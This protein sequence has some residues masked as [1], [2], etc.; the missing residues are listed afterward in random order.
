MYKPR[1]LDEV[2]EQLGDRDAFA[3]HLVAGRRPFQ[4]S[5]VE[6]QWPRDRAVDILH[7]KLDV[8]LDFERKRIAG[9]ATH[10]LTAIVDELK[11]LEFDATE[12]EIGSVRVGRESASFQSQDGKVQVTLPRALKAGAE[13][14]VAI[15]YS[16]APRRG[17]YFV[18]PDSAYPDKPVEAWTQGEDEDSRYWFPCYDY[19]NDRATSEVIATVPDHF[20]AISNGALLCNRHNPAART[21]TFHWRHDV[22]HSTYLITLA[23]GEFVAIEDRAGNTPVLYYV[24]PGREDDARRAF[25]NTPRMIQFFE[26]IIG[27]PYPYSKY[28]QV[29][30]SDFIFGGMENTSATT[31]TADT[32][33][34][35]RAHLDF[36]S[37][38]LVA[39]ELAHQW[40]GD[41]LTCRDWSHAWLNEG[42]ATYFEA[43]WCEENLGADEFAWNLRQDR[44]AYLAE[45]S[46]DYRRPIVCNRYRAPIE[47]FDRHLY[48]KGS[49]VLHMLRRELGDTLF[50]KSLNVYCTRHRGGNVVTADLERA[51]EESTG[52]N[53]EWFFDQWVYKEGHPEIE[54]ASS[55][56]DQRKLASIT[57]KQTQKTSATT[58]LFRFTTALALLDSE[59]KETRHQVEI[60][61][62]EQVFNL[63]CDKAPK[64]VR[65]DPDFDIA[66]TLKHKRGREALELELKQLPEGIGRAAAARE[67]GKEGSP[68]ATAALKDAL[69][70]D[71]FWGVQADAAAALGEVRTDA[72]LDALIEG[73]GGQHPKTR[74]AVARALGQFR[75]N[76]R[77]ASAL[78]ALLEKG[79]ESY[80]VEAETALAL[81]K[82]RDRRAGGILERALQ[83]PSYLDVIRAHALGG[84]AES[85][86]ERALGVGREWSTYGKPPRARVAALGALAKIARQREAWREEIIDYLM[87]LSDDREF[88]VR[89]RLPGA[90]EEIGDSRAIAPLRRLA[91]RELDGRI[92]RRARA[93]VAAISEGRNRTEQDT[94]V[95]EDLDKLRDENKKL[96]Q[97]LEKLEALA[98]NKA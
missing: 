42:F 2:A 12:L 27:V 68:Q 77:A 15:E 72:A 28:A 51:C 78:A 83:R 33:H 88:M 14:E 65:L 58:P 25:G 93:A 45:D 44:E 79:D 40:W 71:K 60:R 98:K 7:I 63:P 35:A 37:D 82:T 74:R 85:R 43:L 54:V 96:Q 55:Y 9:T 87:P 4:P 90:L 76:E 86:D 69:L 31:Q 62:T 22:P 34:D 84:I 13:V 95:R 24:H 73:L 29:A 97:R 20:T 75:D 50:Y 81:G 41:L 92:Q 36:K 53:L 23:A 46:H 70:S 89:M 57:V 8:A 64:S 1:F 80:F 19:P 49:L 3:G 26:R 52:R 5:D 18:G 48:E 10:R 47:L 38:P 6:P 11:T 59:G 39:H 61:E 91:D 94:R 67:L 30:V 66:K 16:G 56:D 17:L 21:R 32:L